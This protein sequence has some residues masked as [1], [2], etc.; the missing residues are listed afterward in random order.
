[1]TTTLDARNLSLEIVRQ[2]FKF[3]EQFNRPLAKVFLALS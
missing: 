3:E 1:M 2:L